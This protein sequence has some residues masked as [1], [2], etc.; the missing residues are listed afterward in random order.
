MYDD[1]NLGW[2]YMFRIDFKKGATYTIKVIRLIFIYYNK[3]KG[4]EQKKHHPTK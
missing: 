1:M 4:S 2:N 3:Y